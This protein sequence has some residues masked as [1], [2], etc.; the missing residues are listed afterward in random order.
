MVACMVPFRTG[1]F[2]GVVTLELSTNYFNKLRYNLDQLRLGRDSYPFL[3]TAEG[4][5]LCHPIDEYAFPSEK[6][7]LKRI[8]GYPSFVAPLETADPRRKRRSRGH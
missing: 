8:Q 6:A 5:C 7:K 3:I 4:T 1:L 2:T